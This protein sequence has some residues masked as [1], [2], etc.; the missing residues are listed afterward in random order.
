[1]PVHITKVPCRQNDPG[2]VV[3]THV[4]VPMSPNSIVWHRPDGGDAP[5]LERLS[6]TWQEV[7]AAY[8]QV[9]DYVSP[10]G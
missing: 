4:P 7:M 9:Y 1:M 10:G 5:W 3:H 6:W 8:R 2:Q